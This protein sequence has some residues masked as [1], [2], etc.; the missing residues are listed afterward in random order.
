MLYLQCT[1]TA[2]W[3]TDDLLSKI[4]DNPILSESFSDPSLSQALTQFQ[5]NPKAAL[6]AAKDNPKVKIYNC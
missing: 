1:C 3:V 6:A 4:H 5:S 2:D